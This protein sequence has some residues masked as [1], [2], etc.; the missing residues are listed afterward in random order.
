MNLRLQSPLGFFGAGLVVLLVIAFLFALHTRYTEAT[1]R[2]NNSRV[3][4]D[5]RAFATAL[6]SYYVDCSQYPVMTMQR[7]LGYGTQRLPKD[8][9]VSRTFRLDIDMRAMTLT[10]P[11][12]YLV[13][14][15]H[16]PFATYRGTT[17]SY[18]NDRSGWILGSWGPDRDQATGGDLQWQRGEQDTTLYNKSENPNHEEW[19]LDRTPQRFRNYFENRLPGQGVANVYNSWESQPSELLLGGDHAQYGEGAFTFDPTNGLR[20][21]GDIWRVKN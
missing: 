16:D 21:Q 6:E 3:H 12:A 1:I 10:T 19:V 14:Y 8:I 15:P 20:S 18:F 9:P 7:N 17:Y 13:S 5:L 2:R 4:A 11:I